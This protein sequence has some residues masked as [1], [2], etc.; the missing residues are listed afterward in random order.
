MEF[1]GKKIGIWGFGVVGQSAL[2]FFHTQ[3]MKTTVIDAKPFSDQ[4]L[5]ILREHNATIYNSDQLNDFLKS[6]DLCL[7]S[8]GIDI[9][10]YLHLPINFVSE[11]DIFDT[12]WRLP[13]I[14]ITGSVGKTSTIHLLGQLMNKAGIGTAVGGNIGYGMLD[15]ITHQ[16]QYEMALLELSS[17]QLEYA[18]HCSPDIAIITNLYPNHLDRHKTV[19]AYVSAKMNVIVHQTK[20]ARAL[21]SLSLYHTVKVCNA[22]SRSYALLIDCE[23]DPHMIEQLRKEHT[24]YG[25]F[26][27]SIYRYDSDSTKKLCDHNVIPPISVRD[28][29]LIIMACLDMLDIDGA[30]LIQKNFPLTVPEHR[31]EYVTSIGNTKIYNDSKSTLPQ[32]TLSAIAQFQGK[33]IA[34]FV[35]GIGKGVDRTQ[36]LI[37]IS[38]HVKHLYLFGTESELLARQSASYR[39]A[40][41]ALPDL[42]SCIDHCLERVTDLDVILLSPAGASYDQ[43]KDYQDRGSFFKTQVLKKKSS[44]M[45]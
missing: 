14:A 29:W 23:T 19:E 38:S 26:D 11:I 13:Y 15:L 32:A 35:G 22:N 17:F 40:V 3:G 7:A 31:V 18:K 24:L 44:L 25:F 6:I 16:D 33:K 21:I 45:R 42:D 34:L 8:P 43:F 9:S 10:S 36:F 2:R 27:E 37:D 12:F 41:T 39:C 28:N 5:N 1:A 30:A 20:D 4:Q